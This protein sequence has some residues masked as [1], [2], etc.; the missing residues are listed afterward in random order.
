MVE[1]SS[2]SP[3]GCELDPAVSCEVGVELVKGGEGE[4]VGREDEGR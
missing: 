2:M 3:T 4:G 1:T